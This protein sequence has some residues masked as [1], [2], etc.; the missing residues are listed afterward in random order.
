MSVSVR[1]IKRYADSTLALNGYLRAPGDGR[2]TP[3]RPASVLLWSQVTGYLLREV[4]FHAIEALSKSGAGRSLGISRRFSDDTLGY[5]TERLEAHRTRLAMARLLQRVKRNKAFDQAFLLGLALDGTGA[6]RSRACRC[7]LCHPYYDAQGNVAGYRHALTAISVVG[8]GLTLPFD[9][10]PYGP[11]DCEYNAGQRLLRRAVAHLGKRFATHVVVDGEYA[12]A[13]FLHTAGDQGLY[14][15]ARLKDNL[16]G[17]FAQA[18]ERFAAAPPHCRFTCQN[19]QVEMWDADDF[20]PWQTLNWERVRVF[21]YRQHKADG[22]TVDAYWLTDFPR[23]RV[24]TQRLYYIAKSRW[25]IE[26]QG[27]NEAKN[28][29]GFEHTPHHHENSLLIHWLLV[30]LTLCIERLYRL[31]Y[32]RRG[33][34][35]PLSAIELLRR[36]RL[37]HGRPRR[38]DPG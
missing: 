35:P 20:D 32:L 31:R 28:H 14:T 10:E 25:E 12:T 36:L 24:S 8:C 19:E 17:L 16:P 22:T 33:N 4:S 7:S 37:A 6:G 13:P 38:E 1:S 18:R 9:V 21:G 23:S 15:V 29:H 26:N 30:F 27:F 2:K 5:F 11:G 34:H 3:T